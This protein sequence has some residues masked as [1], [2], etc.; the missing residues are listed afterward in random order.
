MQKQVTAKVKRCG[1]CQRIKNCKDLYKGLKV[2][3]E[4]SR[5]LQVFTIQALDNEA[6]SYLKGRRYLSAH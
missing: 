4:C 6:S 3:C 5:G 1:T 2:C